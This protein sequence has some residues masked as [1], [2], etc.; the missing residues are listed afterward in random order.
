VLIQSLFIGFDAVFNQAVVA[1]CFRYRQAE[2]GRTINAPEIS[3]SSPSRFG[4][5]RSVPAFQDEL[6]LGSRF[7]WRWNL[8]A[9]GWL[10]HTFTTL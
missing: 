2:N 7:D 9:V 8:Q 4:K 1:G 3:K 5:R 6:K 10:L